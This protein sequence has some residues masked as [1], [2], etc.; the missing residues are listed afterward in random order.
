L[1]LDINARLLKEHRTWNHFLVTCTEKFYLDP[2]NLSVNRYANEP[3][4][5]K[6]NPINPKTYQV[7]IEVINEV[8]S[9]F[10][11]EYYHAGGDE[12]VNK[13]WEDD[14]GVSDYKKKHNVTGDD[15]LQ[16]LLTKELGMIK[17]HKKT[18][19]LW[20]DA[21]T[22]LH[23]DIPKETVLQVWTGSVKDAVNAGHRVIASNVN[24]FYFDCRGGNWK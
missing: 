13:C 4:A 3:T 11:D 6:L 5:G 2:T 22:N 8:T 1:N 17:K 15:L 10:T 14:K 20:E 7:V 18:A 16:T 24:F 23:L 9:W 21:V 19:I 12:P